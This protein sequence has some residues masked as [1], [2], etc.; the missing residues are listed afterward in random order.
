MA[1]RVKDQSLDSREARRKLKVSGKPYW[2]SIGTGLHIGYRKGK[3]GAV[4]VIR[5]YLGGRTYKLETIAE[6]DDFLDADGKDILDFW[7]AQEAARNLR[8]RRSLGRYT[9]KEAIRDYLDRLEGRPSWHDTKM[10]LEAFAVPAFGDRHVSDLEADDL[11]RW[12]RDIAKT[13]ARA[14]TKRGAEQ[15]YRAGNLSEPETQR[16]RQASA[17]R[18]LGLLKAA[19]NLAWREK[20]AESNEAWQRVEPF[21]GVDVPRA[22]YLSVNEAQRLINASQG[23]FRRRGAPVPPNNPPIVGDDNPA[24]LY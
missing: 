20:K 3:T 21:R 19:L 11:R 6:A 18:C 4:W 1:R 13:P 2:R 5:Q 24:D 7:Q 16:K 8:Q 23:A 14:R 10:R 22:R 12:H 17:N 9:V 15:A